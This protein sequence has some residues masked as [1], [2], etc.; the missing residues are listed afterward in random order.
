MRK[1]A[2]II[3]G[4]GRDRR[5]E[6]ALETRGDRGAVVEP[7]TV[8][9]ETVEP[10]AVAERPE[11]AAPAKPAAPTGRQSSPLGALRDRSAHL[12]TET[13]R[14]PATQPSQ[15][16]QAASSS[17]RPAKA[18]RAPDSRAVGAVEEE[19]EAVDGMGGDDRPHDRRCA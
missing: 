3:S 7:E 11:K 18:G 13:R 14:A 15:P 6:L 17:L 16:K 12:P 9:A 1:I 8:E 10:E 4:R 2:A 19:A 5:Q